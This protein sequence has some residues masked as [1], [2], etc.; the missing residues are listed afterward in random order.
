VA[1]RAEPK[2]SPTAMLL[3]DGLR[4]LVVVE[5]VRERAPGAADAA[6]NPRPEEVGKAES[7]AGPIGWS[8]RDMEK[9]PEVERQQSAA[10]PER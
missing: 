3:C 7:S 5:K 10:H 6:R 8:G 9:V 1:A 4:V 2:V